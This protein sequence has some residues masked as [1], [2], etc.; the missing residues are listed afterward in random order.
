MP[1][2]TVSPHQFAPRALLRRSTISVELTPFEVAELIRTL[3]A[4]AVRYAADPET[5]DV[6]DHWFR[7][8]TEL[9]EVGR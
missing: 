3:E 2:Q 7:R 8:V 4:R 9:R 6:A 1:E 5:I